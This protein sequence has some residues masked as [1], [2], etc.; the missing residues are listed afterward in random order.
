MLTLKGGLDPGRPSHSVVVEVIN[1]LSSHLCYLRLL[2]SMT[3]PAWKHLKLT[4]L[5]KSSK[6][7]NSVLC[8]SYNKRPTIHS[9]SNP[10][11]ETNPTILL[12]WHLRTET[13]PG[14]STVA[15]YIKQPCSPILAINHCFM[16]GL[17]H[18][19][20]RPIALYSQAVLLTTSQKVLIASLVPIFWGVLSS[21]PR[22]VDSVLYHPNQ[23]SYSVHT[24][25]TSH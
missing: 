24:H 14:Y 4:R 22:L 12:F 15:L 21:W 9:R 6:V 20:I 8:P 3:Q 7:D 11:C 23:S 17:S 19:V 16:I 13:N 10:I 18:K 1:N 5:D 2:W 25:Q